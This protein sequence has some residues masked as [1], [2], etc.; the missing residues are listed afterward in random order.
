MLFRSIETDNEDQEI[1]VKI[2]RRACEEPLRQI[3]RNAGL[4]SGVILS[5]VLETEEFFDG[6]DAKAEQLTNLRERGIIDPTKVTRTAL[7][8]AASVAGIMLTTEGVVTD[9]EE[10]TFIQPEE[11]LF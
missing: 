5:K 3:M 4:E 11:G 9:L 1:G 2:I 8:N 10:Q 6:F 7:A